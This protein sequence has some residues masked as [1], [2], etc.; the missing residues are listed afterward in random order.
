[1]GRRIVN[2]IELRG[3][4][5]GHEQQLVNVQKWRTGN[6]RA[7]KLNLGSLEEREGG[8]PRKSDGEKRGENHNYQTSQLWKKKT[9]EGGGPS[10]DAKKTPSKRLGNTEGEGS[11]WCK[12]SFETR[13]RIDRSPGD[14][15]RNELGRETNTSKGETGVLNC[16][17]IRGREK[18]FR[19]Y[20]HLYGKI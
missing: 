20:T 14:A 6:R 17:Q 3:S 7:T 11:K 13:P 5:H 1:L 4:P 10:T 2:F 16:G 19:H 12:P 8:L 15:R 9:R 18:K